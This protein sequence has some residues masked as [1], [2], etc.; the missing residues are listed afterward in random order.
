MDK[1]LLMVDVTHKVITYTKIENGKKVE[2]CVYRK[3]DY[4]LSDKEFIDSIME[5]YPSAVK[6]FFS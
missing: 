1:E 6:V 3:D 5:F 4:D 2:E